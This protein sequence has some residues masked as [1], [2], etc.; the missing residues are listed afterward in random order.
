MI[1]L[2]VGAATGACA[3]QQPTY[4][5]CTSDTECGGMTC[6]T[7]GECVVAEDI[8]PDF[9][10]SWVVNGLTPDERECQVFPALELRFDAADTQAHPRLAFHGIDCATGSMTLSRVPR[11]FLYE[12]ALGIDGIREEDADPNPYWDRKHLDGVPRDPSSQDGS[13]VFYLDNGPRL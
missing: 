10:I 12:V 6:A 8:V 2:V 3:E 9:R 7:S 5:T 4:G 13:I 1:V 11:H